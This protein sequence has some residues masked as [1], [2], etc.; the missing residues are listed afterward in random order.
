MHKEKF[1]Y[2]LQNACN[3]VS[4]YTWEEETFEKAKNED[5]PI[6]LLIG[7]F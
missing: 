6:F 2:L 1:C 4:W 5:K 3:P 7:Y